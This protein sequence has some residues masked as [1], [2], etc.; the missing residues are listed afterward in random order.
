MIDFSGNPTSQSN[1]VTP[2]LADAL[3]SRPVTRIGIGLERM[4]S[5]AGDNQLV[6]I[7]IP[8]GSEHDTSRIRCPRI[9]KLPQARADSHRTRD[10]AQVR[11]SPVPRSWS[12]EYQDLVPGNFMITVRCWKT[13]S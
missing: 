7:T 2:Q 4:D 11:N 8:S 1:W 9:R 10:E 6:E 12:F 5:S 3:W 13:R